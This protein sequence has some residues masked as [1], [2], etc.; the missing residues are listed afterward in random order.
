MFSLKSIIV[1]LVF[2]L[3]LN[4]LTTVIPA[5]AEEAPLSRDQVILRMVQLARSGRIA[6]AQTVIRTYLK[7]NSSDGTMHYNLTCLDLLL[8]QKDQAMEDLE[9]ALENGYSNFRLI[10]V[11][12]D[13]NFLRGDIRFEPMVNNYKEKF[14]DDFHS[15]ALYLEESYPPQALDLRLQSTAEGTLKPQATVAFNARELLVT[16][17]VNDPAYIG[18]KPPWE[19][20]CGVLVN[21]VHPVSPDDYDS[22]RYYSYGFFV[23]DGK[24]QATL[25]GRHKEVL[26]EPAPLLNSV[27]TRTEN[28]IT[29]E[30]SIPW[31]FFE[32]YAPSLDP[33]MGLNILYFSA[34]QGSSQPVYSLMPEKKMTF[35]PNTWRRYIPVSFLDSDRSV[36]RLRGRLYNRLTEGIELGLQLAFWSE[37][38]GEAQCRLSFHPQDNPG[39]TTGAE[40]V[41]SVF[42]EPEL[43]FFN[44]SLDLSDM[45][46]GSFILRAELTDPNGRIFTREF[47]FD[48][49]QKNWLG[50]L[51]ERVHQLNN[52]EKSTLQYHLFLLTRLAENR[53]PQ[54]EASHIHKAYS[55]MVDMITL[56]EAGSSCLP[57]EGL[58]HSGFTTGVM[59]MRFC[60]MYLPAGFKKDNN[61]KLL[62]VLP[63]EPQTEDLWAQNLAKTLAE[64]KNTVVLVPQSHGYS[65]LNSE[66][67]AKETV[68]AMKWATQLFN[69][70][71]ITLVGLGNG[72][73]AALGASLLAPEYCERVLL[74]G[75]QLYRDMREFGSDKVTATLGTNPNNL[76][77]TIASSEGT[78]EL[79]KVVHLAMTEL[80]FQT[81]QVTI[82]NEALDSNWIIRWFQA[83]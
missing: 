39:T 2:L 58:F 36:T 68:L 65:G 74:D 20:G 24:P 44:F 32:P 50:I 63:P 42:S 31:D 78:S 53:H 56:S 14:I 19:G 12:P 25:V 33:E 40:I 3:V 23:Q 70:K 30:M 54:T 27:I 41:E 79:S 59:T 57:D 45:P 55:R 73:D 72:A 82:K 6:E 46:R 38:E 10:E 48:N 37:A 81:R 34:G 1:S 17:S 67:A 35:Q 18:E 69:Q 83:E 4:T 8:K 28:Q 21:L 52:V 71:T 60:S 7:D 13:L 29:Y 49:F 75:N 62:M 15:R 5:Q 51:N 64:A 26:L 11:D 80:G 61:L 43:N 9:N 76:T 77:Y 16:L 47:L 22:R 66:M